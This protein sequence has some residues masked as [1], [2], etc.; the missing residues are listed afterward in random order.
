[1]LEFLEWDEPDEDE[2]ANDVSI[3]LASAEFSKEVTGTV[4]WLNDHGLCVFRSILIADSGRRAIAD[5]G[6]GDRGFRPS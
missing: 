4:L 6:D 2:F 3:V 5:S 1:M